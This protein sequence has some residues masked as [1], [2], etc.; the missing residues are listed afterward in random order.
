MNGSTDRGLIYNSMVKLFGANWQTTLSGY[1]AMLFGAIYVKPEIIHWV[2]EPCQG[3]LWNISLYIAGG[4]F[5]TMAHQAKAKNVTGGLVQ[6]T[7][8]G[9]IAEPGTQTLVD[10][11][12]KASIASGD[13]A[14]TP[15]QKR[16]VQS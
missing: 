6:Q 11:T 15:E 10:Q 1:I 2:P 4:S 9:A 3:I 8:S 13:D 16:A 7:V 12:I 14:V 5:L